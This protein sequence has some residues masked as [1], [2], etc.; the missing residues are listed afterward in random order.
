MSDAFVWNYIVWSLGLCIILVWG[1]A[2]D[3][4]YGW[5][6]FDYLPMHYWMGSWVRK[7]SPRII[8]PEMVGVQPMWAQPGEIFVIRQVYVDKHD[9]CA[10]NP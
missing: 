6:M 9:S 10:A 3:R 8:V 5:K 7:F 1:D 4:R 2:S